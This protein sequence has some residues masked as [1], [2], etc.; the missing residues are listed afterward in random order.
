MAFNNQYLGMNAA[1][2]AMQDLVDE[3]DENFYINNPCILKT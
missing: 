1:N 3:F 2:E